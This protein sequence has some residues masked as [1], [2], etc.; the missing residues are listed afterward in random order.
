MAMESSDYSDKS[1]PKRRKLAL[2]TPLYAMICENDASR[3][4]R[5]AFARLV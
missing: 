5:P 2:V 1:T 3:H 4:R